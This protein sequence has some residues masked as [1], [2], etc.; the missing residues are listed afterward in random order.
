MSKPAQPAST[1]SGPF[2]ERCYQVSFQHS[3]QSA[4]ELFHTITCEVERFSPD[5]LAN[6][7]KTKGAGHCL[8]V[9]DEFKI[10]ILGPWNGSVRVTEMGAD[11]FELITLENH[12]EAGQIR[13]CLRPHPHLPDTLQF[14]I[15]SWAR[16]RDGLVAFAYDTL[17]LGKKVQEQTWRTFCERVADYCGGLPLGPVAV[18]TIKQDDT[19]TEVRHE[20]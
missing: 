7:E 2:F 16:S 10:R 20:A 11:Y 12:P 6:F 3:N 4:A 15:H 9:G 1:G 17:G 14:E 8:A 13:F 5:L 19:K 18:E